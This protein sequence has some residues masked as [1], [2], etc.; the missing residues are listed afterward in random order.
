MYLQSVGR[1]TV[2]QL[3]AAMMVDVMPTP[4]RQTTLGRCDSAVL[5][6]LFPGK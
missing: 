2:D 6:N 1:W 4:P 5:G 3:A